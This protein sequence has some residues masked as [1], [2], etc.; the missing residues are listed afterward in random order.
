MSLTE[1]KLLAQGGAEFRLHP[2]SSSESRSTNSSAG[3]QLLQA[4]FIGES[5]GTNPKIFSQLHS[6][7]QAKN[8]LRAAVAGLGD[9]ERGELEKRVGKSRLEE[10]VS[11]SEESDAQLFW[12]GANQIALRLKQADQLQPAGALYSAIVQGGDAVPAEA[13]K[14][15]QLELDAMTG[16]G[17]TG[18][19]LEFLTQQ[20]VKQATDVKTIAPMILGS[21]VYSLTRATVLGRMAA[22]VEGSW[23]TRGAGAR[24]TASLAGFAVE[25]PTFALSSRA[26]ISATDG[27]V[28]WDGASVAK[29]LLGASLTLGALKVFGHLG[30]QGFL[31][32]HGIGEME[33]AQLTRFQKFSQ[34]AFGQGSMFAGMMFSHK[35]EEKVGL[36][37]HVDGST[38][39]TDTLA[40]MV[41]MGI[42]GHLGNKMLGARF[43]S[44]QQELGIRTNLYTKA[45]DSTPRGG[46]AAS[47]LGFTG[48]PAYASEGLGAIPRNFAMSVTEE[49]TGSRLP[50]THAM[51]MMMGSGETQG[52]QHPYLTGN[53]V[54]VGNRG[55]PAV[56]GVNEAKKLG[57][58]PVVFYS[59][60]DA[61]SL[62]ANMDGVIALPLKGNTSNET[63]NNIPARMAALEKFMKEREVAPER[64]LAWEGWGFKSEDSELFALYEKMGI[65]A[66]GAASHVMAMMGNKISARA[67]A[68][69]A[70]V[71]TVPGS[72]KLQS[73]QEAL[74]FAR[75]TGFPVIIKGGDTGGGKGI[76]VALTEVDLQDAYD[77]AKREALSTSGSDVVFMEKFIPSMRHLEVQV[78]GDGKGSFTVVGV[79]D[80]TMQRNKQKVL[81]EDVSTFLA[82]E[83][84]QQAKVIGA[85]IMAQLKADDPRKIGYEGPGTIELIWDR[86]DD[87][88]YFMEMNTRLQVEHTVTEMVSG[89][90]LLREQLLIGSGRELSFGNV[91]PRGHAI[92]ARIT[93]E[94]PYNK[95]TPS[96]GRILHMRLPETSKDGRS[97]VRVDSGVEA[98]REIPSHYDS[99]IAKLIVWAPTR[100]Q[101]VSAL[102]QALGEFEVLGIKT[103]IPFLRAL[104][105]TPEFLE[106]KGYDTN[107]IEKKFLNSDAGKPLFG[108][109]RRELGRSRSF[110]DQRTAVHPRSRRPQDS[111]SH[112]RR[113]RASR[114]SDRR[115]VLRDRSG[116][117]GSF[118]CGIR[119]FAGARRGIEDLEIRR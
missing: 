2:S 11:L 89:R 39:V 5:S 64:L 43:A 16:K 84:L 113:T 85:K 36:R 13:R 45:L 42:G 22:T 70:G 67:V 68:E 14:Q 19:R 47:M 114:R 9:S 59:E 101:A 26:L 79:R 81:E 55:E 117:G 100:A 18:R 25:V 112:P 40:A 69:R 115:R 71:P 116:R 72:G 90:N 28:S 44:F 7:L 65:R 66:A 53:Y 74:E 8:G 108:P 62:H 118:G 78:I 110:Q 20:F 54:V 57:A 119:R 96:T 37:P 30:N 50:T 86:N 35:L 6:S 105:G 102:Q 97:I 4:F 41:S 107:F 48:G 61:N 94:D 10:I 60:A 17:G 32:L 34:A 3:F 46:K 88:L 95:F 12:S 75:Q 91:E 87:Q 29:D 52:H 31:K 82:P 51:M 21:A 83:M 77:S 33:A 15:A 103:N 58:T 80:C 93:S 27:G 24:F 76:R 111:H 63:Y 99:M 49:S 109:G 98:G 56:R 1:S 38:A 106:G 73:Y 92:E 104:S 23:F